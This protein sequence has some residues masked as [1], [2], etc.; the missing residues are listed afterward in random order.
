MDEIEQLKQN[1]INELQQQQQVMQQIA[2]LEGIVKGYLES[3]AM[4][5]YNT[6]K[7][8]HTELAVQFLL[9]V[10]QFVQSGNIQRKITDSQMKEIL[11]KLNPPKRDFRIQ[12]K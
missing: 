1:R 7:T 3:D 4:E 2:Q 10:S 12:R 11:L 8:A 6:L 5:R 9:T